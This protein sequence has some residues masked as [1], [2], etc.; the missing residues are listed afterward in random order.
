M[1]YKM[2][3]SHLIVTTSNANI[4][5]NF[6]MLIMLM[7]CICYIV[8]PLPELV[9]VMLIVGPKM[10]RMS[11]TDTGQHHRIYIPPATPSPSVTVTDQ[12][13][14]AVS[15]RPMTGLCC[16]SVLCQLHLS[17]TKSPVPQIIPDT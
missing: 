6:K 15:H 1:A 13:T 10:A 14:Y 17:V 12:V 8:V 9:D 11:N 4:L 7:I 3:K 2:S 5:S 16:D